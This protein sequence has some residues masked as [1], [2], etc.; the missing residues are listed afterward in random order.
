MHKDSVLFSS[1]TI[2]LAETDAYI[3]L[4]NRVCY[5][6]EP[7]AN[8][9]KLLSDDALEKAQ[10]LINMPVV[11]KY[12]VNHNNQPTF[13]GHEA[14]IDENGELQFNTDSIGTH[15]Q[16]YIQEDTVDVNGVQKTLPC[17]FAKYRIWTRNKNVVS[18]VKRLYSEGKLYSSWEIVTLAYEFKDNV[19]T[20]TDYSFLA[21]CLLGYEY[22]F[23]AYGKDA[24][25]ISMSNLEP[26][27]LIAEALAK[28]IIN[29][30]A[31]EDNGLKKEDIKKQ[32]KVADVVE[33]TQSKENVSDN[34]DNE[35]ETSSLTEWDLRN[36]LQKACREKLD[37]WCWVTFHFPLEKTIW[38]EVDGRESELDFVLMTYEVNDNDE[39][40]VSDPKDVKLTV[41]VSE[42]N[43]TI[44]KLNAELE[45]K[46]EALIKAND[47]I[48]NL[49][50]EVSDLKVYK[51]K[52][53]QIE[54]E[55]LEAQLA[56]EREELKN[57]AIKSGYITIEEIESSE[58]LQSYI[59]DLNRK[60]IQAIIADRVVSSLKDSE[61]N[62]GAKNPT[63]EIEVSNTKLDITN[64]DEILDYKTVMKAF[65]GK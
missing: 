5:Y 9:V 34:I 8:G 63:S 25:A 62:S 55:K 21:N 39:V 41:S 18:A 16:V 11:A 17:L 35:T 59:N 52:F 3:E 33:D 27:L 22:S 64:D 26:Q 12:A 6:D 43:S 32:K 42:I 36:K 57:Y 37:K 53:E 10:T 51:E 58:E 29:S 20:I 4:T 65:L 2:N 31:K 38:V 24:K 1:K 61:E 49:S 19:K 46:N 23:P 45:E 56:Q 28:D 44:E 15:T 60:E 40:I 13:K 50:T 7:N 47:T 54:Q 14:Y 48:Q 30:K